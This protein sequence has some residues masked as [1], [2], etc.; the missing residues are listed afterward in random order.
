MNLIFI[1]ENFHCTSFKCKK[2][3]KFRSLEVCICRVIL[4]LKTLSFVY[5]CLNNDS[6]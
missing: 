6:L 1:L 5:F 2:N 3:E 4:E